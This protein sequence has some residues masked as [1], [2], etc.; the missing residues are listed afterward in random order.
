[1]AER[2]EFYV[3]VARTISR[4]AALRSL[5]RYCSCHSNIKFISSRHRVISSIYLWYYYKAIFPV[6]TP[7]ACKIRY[8]MTLFW[9]HL[10]TWRKYCF[11]VLNNN[12]ISRRR[13]LDI[14]RK[15]QELLFMRITCYQDQACRCFVCCF[16]LI[17]VNSDGKFEINSFSSI[18]DTSI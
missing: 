6:S 16:F 15:V 17:T 5:V 10:M 13:H 1:M 18:S 4:C 2:Y 11:C 7:I 8:V 9:Q 14:A 12:V 3:L